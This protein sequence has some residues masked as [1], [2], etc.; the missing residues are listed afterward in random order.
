VRRFLDRAIESVD[1]GEDILVNVQDSGAPVEYGDA[2]L[3]A[4]LASVR[5]L[6]GNVRA[7]ARLFTRTLGR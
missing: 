3:R 5:E 2:E 6:L 4:G 7:G 1:A